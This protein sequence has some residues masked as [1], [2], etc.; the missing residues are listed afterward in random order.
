MVLFGLLLGLE[1]AEFGSA[2]CS[3]VGI[4]MNDAHIVIIIV[5]VVVI[6]AASIFSNGFKGRFI[7]S[8][9]SN[10]GQPIQMRGVD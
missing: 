9:L 8:L 7:M 5:V 3:R 2:V 6:V 10:G 4:N 1:C